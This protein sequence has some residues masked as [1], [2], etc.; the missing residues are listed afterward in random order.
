MA[1]LQE[2][3]ISGEIDDIIKSHQVKP[4]EVRVE[5]EDP[6]ISKN[7]S[8][9][10]SSKHQLVIPPNGETVEHS[11]PK[12]PKKKKCLNEECK[13]RVSV[14]EDFCSDHQPKPPLTPEQIQSGKIALYN[15]H[16]STYMAT[17]MLSGAYNNSR[18]KLD[19]L[20]N[21]LIE[22]KEQIEQIHENLIEYYG[23][24]NIEQL[25]NPILA[26][27]MI[28]TGHI[29]TVV[30]ENNKKNGGNDGAVG[31]AHQQNQ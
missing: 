11:K 24:E 28:T 9:T 18:F 1:S 21:L 19:G 6:N 15:L 26:L 3:N 27:A 25:C 7:N 22:Q 13:R 16:L 31:L 17:E 5:Q 23:I 30:K 14:D 10:L 29:I 8:D 2:H 4:I 20:T 12:K